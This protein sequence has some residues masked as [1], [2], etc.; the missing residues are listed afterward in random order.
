MAILVASRNQIES[1]DVG[2]GYAA[3]FSQR[4]LLQFVGDTARALGISIPVL[5]CR[6]HGGP[7]Q[8]YDERSANFNTAAALARARLSLAEDVRAGLRYLH[9]DM[10]AAHSRL[11]ARE[12]VTITVD[13]IQLC[14]EER[15]HA[16]LPVVAY[17]V[18]TEHAD[19]GVSSIE[20]LDLFLAPLIDAIDERDLPRPTTVVVRCGTVCRERRNAGAFD[21]ESAARLAAHVH[22][23]YGMLVK[24]H[25][26]DYA[27]PDELRQHAP[28]GV[29]MLNI[30]P[31][32]GDAETMCL[33]ELAKRETTCVPD[34]TQSHFREQ[35][36]TAVRGRAPVNIWHPS[37][38]APPEDVLLAT[39]GHYV[40]AHPAVARARDVLFANCVRT[41]VAE[42]PRENVVQHVQLVI[43]NV[44]RHLGS[45]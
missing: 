1:P 38:A 13:L 33:L 30:G 24:E 28:V 22:A 12:L 29:D 42:D 21:A 44:V 36:L 8:R 7:W 32:V 41:G 2:R 31:S 35:L 15:A 40:F 26:G 25:N 17:E 37:G 6:D 10:S 3:P 14:E 27:L 16:G 43:T 4:P 20:D 39:C 5:V 45:A 34:A 23:T 18:S 11:S 19:G 9:V